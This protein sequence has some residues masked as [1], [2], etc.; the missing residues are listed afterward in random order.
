MIIDAGSTSN[1]V[2]GDF[3]GTDRTGAASLSN[4]AEGVLIQ[5]G[6]TGN[7]VGGTVAAARNIISGN[8]VC[9]VYL[10]DQGTSGNLVEGDYIGTNAAGSAALPNLINGVD[11]VSGASGNTIG[12][13][14]TAARDIV[15]GNTYNGVVIASVGAS[16]NTIE[17]DYIGLSASGSALGNGADGVVVLGGATNNTIGGTATGSADVISANGQHGVLITDANTVGN[18]VE[19]DLIGTDATG[20]KPLG[21]HSDGVHFSGLAGNVVGNAFGQT[22]PGAGNTIAFNGANGFAS[23]G[24]IQ[25]TT[26]LGNSIFGNGSLGIS[27]AAV[28]GAMLEPAPTLKAPVVSGGTTTVRG[29]TSGAPLKGGTLII[30]FFASPSG[31]QGKARW[32]R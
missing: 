2:A 29:T 8:A 30:Q 10:M 1:V 15:S 32:A 31:N 9:G 7:T 18:V 11:I 3:I 19:G 17:G 12:G 23:D 24:S 14:T 4:G 21:N 5:G 22:N 25:S 6:A 26:I 16:S 20:A 13:T 27:E 28:M